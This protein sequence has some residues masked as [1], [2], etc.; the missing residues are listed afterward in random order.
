MKPS[1]YFV[2]Y[3]F[4]KKGIGLAWMC[5]AGR[6]LTTK[7]YNVVMYQYSQGWLLMFQYSQGWL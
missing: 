7:Y 3:K 1:G 5:Q 6:H 2:S 4:L